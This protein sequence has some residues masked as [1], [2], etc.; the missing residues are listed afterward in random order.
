[1]RPKNTI[2]SGIYFHIDPIEYD[3]LCDTNRVNREIAWGVVEGR[4]Y[5]TVSTCL[6]VVSR[7]KCMLDDVERPT[8]V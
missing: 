1:M 3:Y 6:Q 8:A 2:R 4:S 7:R 5:G